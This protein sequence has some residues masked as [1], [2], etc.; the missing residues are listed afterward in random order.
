MLWA[1]DGS[2]DTFRIRIWSEDGDGVEYVVYDNGFEGSTYENGQPID[3][4]NIVVHKD[5]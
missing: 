4:G 5:K 2:P 3:A 1:G